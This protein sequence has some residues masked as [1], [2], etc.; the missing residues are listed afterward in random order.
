MEKLTTSKELHLTEEDFD[1]FTCRAKFL[2]ADGRISRS[3]FTTCV[4]LELNSYAHRKISNALKSLQDSS[5]E[6]EIAVC[7]SQK[8][9]M[10][11]FH[12]RRMKKQTPGEIAKK[13]TPG[14]IASGNVAASEYSKPPICIPRYACM[15]VCVYACMHVCRYAY[16][17]LSLSLSLSLS[18]EDHAVCSSFPETNGVA[19]YTF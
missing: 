17:S 7:L 9:T 11:N 16:I 15:H 12:E 2:N 18:H 19:L 1:M 3:D 8:I 14:E 4:R 13:Q 10:T 5:K 6:E